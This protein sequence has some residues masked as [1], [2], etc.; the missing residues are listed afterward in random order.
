MTL[1][2]DHLRIA[3]ARETIVLPRVSREAILSRLEQSGSM[4]QLRE[5]L[6]SNEA[7][8]AVRLTAGQ[9]GALI[10]LIERWARDVDG[11]NRGLPPGIFELRNA[12]HDD[13]RDAGSD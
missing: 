12:L 4:H 6:G 1:K 9:K 3:L 5:A 10:Q 13:L 8:E 2:D 7:P 11:L